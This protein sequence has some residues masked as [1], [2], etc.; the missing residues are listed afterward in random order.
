[1]GNRSAIIDGPEPG[2]KDIVRYIKAELKPDRFQPDIRHRFL[3]ACI[4]DL[5]NFL[6]RSVPES[7]LLEILKLR[8][9]IF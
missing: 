9:D 6:P 4:I 5:G 8:L 2:R 1:M 7:P 3:T